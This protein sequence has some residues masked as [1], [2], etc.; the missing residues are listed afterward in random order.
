MREPHGENS[1]VDPRKNHRVFVQHRRDDVLIIFSLERHA[2]QKF[3]A[4]SLRHRG[5]PVTES[6]DDKTPLIPSVYTRPFE[7]SGVD[8]GPCP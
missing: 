5:L 6:N 3:G 4:K 2:P 7:Y 8:F 1:F